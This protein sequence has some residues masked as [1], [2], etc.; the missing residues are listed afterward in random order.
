MRKL[1]KPK[2]A[3]EPTDSIPPQAKPDIAGLVN[4]MYEQ[5]VALEKKVDTLISRSSERPFKG[6]RYSRPFQRF[7]HFR[8]HEK[9][10]QGN[11]YREK[12]FTQA[13]CAD[14]HKECEVPFKPSG[15]RPVYCKDCFS[16]RKQEGAFKREYDK[17]PGAEGDFTQKQYSDKKQARKNRGHGGEKPVFHRRKKRA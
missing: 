16:R 13:V 7:D 15:D 12:R 17:R 9:R 14:C 3:S 8:R 2:S 1:I 6:E 11:S 10:D 4:K 5:L